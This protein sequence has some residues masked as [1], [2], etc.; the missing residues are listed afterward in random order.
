MSRAAVLD[1]AHH[2]IRAEVH[3]GGIGAKVV[4]KNNSR[5]RRAMIAAA[6]AVGI[7]R[8]KAAVGQQLAAPASAHSVLMFAHSA[9][10]FV[11]SRRCCGPN[12]DGRRTRI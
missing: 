5:T 1:R 7:A 11:S 12:P 10:M 2:L 3:M 6:Y 4:P 8:H 9:L